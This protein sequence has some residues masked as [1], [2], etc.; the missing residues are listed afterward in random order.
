RFIA[1]A[2]NL[3]VVD[4]AQGNNEFI[5]DLSAQRTWLLEGR[6]QQKLAR[7]AGVSPAQVRPSK[8]P[9][10][11]CCVRRRRRRTRSVHSGCVG[12]VIEP[13]NDEFAGAE[14]VLMVE[15]N[16]CNAVMR[17]IAV[18]PGSKST[19][20][21]K[22]SRRN[23]GYP[24]SGRRLRVRSRV[25]RSASGR[26]GAVADDARAWEVGRGHSSCEAGEQGRAICC[27][28]GGAKGRGRGECAPSKHAPDT[29]PG[30]ACH[31]RWP[32]A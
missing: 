28:V 16:M 2:I 22:G 14:T 23:L 25:R 21:A 11:E 5:A 8:P 10:S 19:S 15:R 6:R 20:R 32:H 24:T 26:R 1:G 30:S 12:C 29:V 9:G 18:P 3:A 17:G 7:S 13:R 4:H 27:G 31:T